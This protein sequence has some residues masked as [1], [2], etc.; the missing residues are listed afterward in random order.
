MH[1]NISF[2]EYSEWSEQFYK[3]LLFMTENKLK[4]CDQYVEYQQLGGMDP[5][6]MT[7]EEFTHVVRNV[8]D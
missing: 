4:R 6:K 8:M 7:E 5:Y 1:W 2:G 3:L